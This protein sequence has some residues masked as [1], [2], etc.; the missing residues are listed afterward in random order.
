[1]DAS[2]PFSKSGNFRLPVV[3]DEIPFILLEQLSTAYLNEVFP[4]QIQ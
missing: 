2:T 3:E 4:K 1:M